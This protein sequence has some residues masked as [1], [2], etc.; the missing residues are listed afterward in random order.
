MELPSA[1]SVIQNPPPAT[2]SRS[3][4]D[5]LTD[6]AMLVLVGVLQPAMSKDAPITTLRYGRM[7]ILPGKQTRNLARVRHERPSIPQ[8]RYIRNGGRIP[9]STVTAS[10]ASGFAPWTRERFIKSR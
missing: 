10:R 2:V 1:T 3:S 8:S 7:A 6:D 4:Q 5:P 9:S